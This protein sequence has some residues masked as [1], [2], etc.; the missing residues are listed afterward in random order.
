MNLQVVNFWRYECAFTYLIMLVHM[1]GI[2]CHIH[3]SFT[4]GC[5]FVF[6][7]VEHCCATRGAY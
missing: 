6:F 5:A 3:A 2:Y 1:P 7:A 4:R